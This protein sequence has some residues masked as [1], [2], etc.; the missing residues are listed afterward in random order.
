MFSLNFQ[1]VVLCF[2][3]DLLRTEV[4]DIDIQG[5]SILIIDNLV[6]SNESGIIDVADHSVHLTQQRIH[7]THHLVESHQ[8]HIPIVLEEWVPVYGG[9][10]VMWIVVPKS[11]FDS[12][13][14]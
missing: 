10:M 2:N 4:T 1:K 5:K 12:K 9:T 11:H 6:P 14:L 7:R 3:I 8:W 13:S